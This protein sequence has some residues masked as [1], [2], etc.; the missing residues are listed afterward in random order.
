MDTYYIA[1]K[2]SDKLSKTLSK[3][4]VIEIIVKTTGLDRSEIVQKINET[5]TMMDQMV[6]EEGAAYIV[7]DKLNVSLEADK[8]S[9]TLKIDQLLAG[10]SNVTVIG[11][12]S[13]I[14]PTNT[15]TRKDNTIGKV[16]NIE[17]LDNTG[18]IRV[19]LWDGKVDSFIQK[20]I[21]IGDILGISGGNVK[22]GYKDALEISVGAHG[23]LENNIT[24][25]KDSDFPEIPKA[26]KISL[27]SL[28]DATGEVSI[29]GKII[30]KQPTYEFDRDGRKGRVASLTVKDDTGQTRVTFWNDDCDKY[31]NYEIGDEISISSLRVNTNKY[32]DKELTFNSYSVIDKIS[33]TGKFDVVIVSDPDESL[34]IK[35][36]NEGM[37]NITVVGKVVEKFDLKEFEKE[38]RTNQVQSLLIQDNTGSIR[39]TFWGNKTGDISTITADNTVKI[40]FCRSRFNDYSKEI[41]ITATD[42]SVVELNPEEGKAIEAVSSL[43]LTFSDI[44]SV[45]R[46]VSIV[47]KISKV[48]EERTV[49]V[50]DGDAKVLNLSV[51]DTEGNQGKIAAWDDNINK[52]SDLVEDDSVEL[53]NVKIKPSTGDYG[54][55]VTISNNTTVSSVENIEFMPVI[56]TAD[57]LQKGYY[58]KASLNQLSPNSSVHVDG[59]IVK[60]FRP[61]IYDGCSSC[62]RKVMVDEADESIGTCLEHGEVKTEPKLILS[63]VLD[64]SID[65]CTVKFF[66]NR[67]EELLGEKAKDAKE[68][69]ERLSD[70]LAPVAHLEMKAIWVEGRVGHDEVRDQ[71]YITVDKFG[72]PDINQETDSILSRYE[73]Y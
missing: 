27:N 57:K 62:Q 40:S 73:D 70:P 22:T 18:S 55:E 21:S 69:I 24:G 63:L 65:T 49:N 26:E 33:D 20:N 11:R 48:F 12:I 58:H 15:F 14:Y 10:Q 34:S 37:N 66:G 72:Y 59:T 61:T 52:I 71:I 32:G 45:R 39:V 19:S 56:Q 44:S 13:K 30:E 28:I 7:A 64:D 3:D 47:L 50:R 53:N 51:V 17:L 29:E 43:K 68:K 16:R 35:D 31:L 41:E 67:A 5:I 42:K 6:N 25:I 54:P 9:T 23:L 36:I 2:D 4:E 1:I 46:G 38:G 60:V 8:T